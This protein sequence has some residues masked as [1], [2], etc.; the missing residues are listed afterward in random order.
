MTRLLLA[1]CALLTLCCAVPVAL[2]ADA[3]VTFGSN[4][5][6]GAGPNVR[7][8][9][10][11]SVSWTGQGGSDFSQHP[12][13]F[14]DAGQ[15]P[16]DAGPTATRTFAAAG[17]YTY[18]CAIHGSPGGGGMGGRITVTANHAPVAS[19]T[20]PSSGTA[21]VAVPFDA[22][23]SSDQDGGQTLTYRWDW[24]GNGTADDVTATP[25]TTH[26]FATVGSPTVRLTVVDS[27]S[28]AV[29]P[30][31]G[32]A[33]HAIAIAAAPGTGGGGGGGG[34]TTTPSGGG[35]TTTTTSGGVTT[36]TRAPDGTVIKTTTA[37]DGTVTK[38]SVAPAPVAAKVRVSGG[39]LRLRLSA[40]ATFHGTLTRGGKRVRTLTAKLAK[41]DVAVKLGK[42]KQGRYAVRFT[43]TGASGKPS[44]A[45]TLP[46]RIVT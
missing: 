32:T 14:D 17:V 12:L 37:P 38:T 31:S 28:D 6:A 11:G 43:L 42:L 21:G 44:K 16:A 18:Y 41:G 29:G 39:K 24:D 19:F 20:A 30:E 36:T 26:A 5:Y 34:T 2:A 40:R 33:A 13:R 9:P 27:N 7:I 23:G 8:S 10:G 25:T 4:F 22:S 1:L 46:F 15:A 35:T 45:R 3:D